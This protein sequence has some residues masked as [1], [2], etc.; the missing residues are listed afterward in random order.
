MERVIN[1]A[2]ILEDGTVDRKGTLKTYTG[3]DG[4]EHQV[5]NLVKEFTDETLA[6]LN[7]DDPF[8]VRD[9]LN[10]IKSKTLNGCE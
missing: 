10:V 8:K 5:R 1:T 3:A 6:Q 2:G 7:L 4:K 9:F